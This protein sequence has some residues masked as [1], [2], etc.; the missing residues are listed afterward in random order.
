MHVPPR[1]PKPSPQSFTEQEIRAEG[2]KEEYVSSKC[3]S[4]AALKG[5]GAELF[6][7]PK[8]SLGL[9]KYAPN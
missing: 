4:T 3:R 9:V 5:L 8:A 7:E 6:S 1:A 2:I